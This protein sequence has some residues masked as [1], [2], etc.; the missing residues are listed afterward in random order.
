MSNDQNSRPTIMVIDDSGTIRRAA[1]TILEQAGY[2][3]E[4]AEDGFEALARIGDCR[5]ALVLCDILMPRLDGYRTCALIKKSRQ[6]HATPVLMLSSKDGLFD[7][8]RGA[9]AGCSASVAKPFSRDSLLS[10]VREHLP[11]GD[12]MFTH[13]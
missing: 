6:F 13:H 3:V 10:A 2:R 11:A 8:A 12:A 5:P 7:R 1:A 9:L 4:Q